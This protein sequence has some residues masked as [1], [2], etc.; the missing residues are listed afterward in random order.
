MRLQPVMGAIVAAAILVTPA[1]AKK[2]SPQDEALVRA[3]IERVY[4]PYTSPMPEAP[5][6]G[7]YAPE[8]NPGAALDGYELP[9]TA[10]LGAL[11]TQW[12]ALMRSSNQLYKLNGFD[13][14]C[15][16][17]DNDNSTAKLVSQSFALKGKSQ[18]AVTV[19]YSPGTVDGKD[20]GAPL[21]FVFKQED[22]AWKLDDLKFHRFTTLR[23]GLASDIRQAT[24]DLKTADF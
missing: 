13:W 2:P 7:S 20:S 1:L 5:D 4:T 17:Q 24:K 21:V 11:V 10:S 9:Y 3:M 22:G 6:D 18:M 16:C 23:K 12:G 15:Q 14:Y 19:L 8:N